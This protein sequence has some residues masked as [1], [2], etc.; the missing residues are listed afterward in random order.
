[1]LGPFTNLL[2]PGTAK[3]CLTVGAAESRR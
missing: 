1:V 2:V 3:N